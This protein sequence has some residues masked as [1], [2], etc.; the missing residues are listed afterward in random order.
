[1]TC[2]DSE[3]GHGGR[4][5][6]RD[7]RVAEPA[8]DPMPVEYRSPLHGRDTRFLVFYAPDYDRQ[9]A[10]ESRAVAAT[11]RRL[12]TELAKHPDMR[13]EAAR[14]GALAREWQARA[15]QY[16]AAAEAHSAECVA[17]LEEECLAALAAQPEYVFPEFVL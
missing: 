2:D 14:R 1:M 6:I 15:E 12:G 3:W 13:D 7:S 11:Y 4:V 8:S 10:A 16:E 5:T 17:L 9:M